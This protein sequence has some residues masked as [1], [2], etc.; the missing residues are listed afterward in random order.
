MASMRQ[1]RGV[2]TLSL[3]EKIGQMMLVGYPAGE[4]G[5]DV[6]RGV[7]ERRPMGNLILFAG[8]M[9]EPSVIYERLAGLR[10]LVRQR[11]GLSPLVS[12]DQEGGIVARVK[13][14]FTP[15]PGAMA[16]AAAVAGG[17]IGLAE[18][19]AM[20]AAVAAELRA[21]GFNWNLAPV[22]DV[23]VNRQNPVIGVRSFGEDPSAV[24]ELAAAY[25]RGL[26]R[27]GVA[28]TAKHFPGHGDTDLDSHLALPRVG[29]DLARL[30]AVELVPFRRLIAQGIAS[31]MTAHVL[32]PAVEPEPI[33]ATLSRR[34][35]SGLLRERLGYGGLIVTDC[36]EMKAI[37]GRY[38]DAAVLA[39][40]AGADVLCVSHTARLQ[41]AAFDAVKAA[42]LSGR[43]PESRIDES[44]RRVLAVKEAFAVEEEPKPRDEAVAS[45]RSPQALA[46][47]ERIADASMTVLGG[48]LPAASAGGLYLDLS[49]ETQT[50]VE[51]AALYVAPAPGAKPT[52]QRT[53]GA[54]T[55]AAALA[56]EG[57]ALELVE[58]PIDPDDESIDAAV[59]RIGRLPV[60][61]GLYALSR[62]PGQER[63]VRRVAEACAASGAPL[64]FVAMR[65]PY[66]V[67]LALAAAGGG[68]P[69]LCAYEYTEPS[70]AAAA[71]ALV[72]GASARGACPVTVA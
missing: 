47:A 33:P 37:H 10:A 14:G 19:E 16:M 64:A 66:D 3:D 18:V 51:S 48:S 63:L 35:L 15:M 41:E 2:E 45:L 6:M 24:A 71:R 34:V 62:Q 13:A 39:V 44:V 28:A 17:E 49:P 72:R 56:A 26:E 52:A 59:A 61:L 32:F 8:N 67:G 43:I 5:L 53:A 31:I 30:D 70:T 1:N 65:D 58:L 68:R 11:T 46:L 25:A 54:K 42:V 9:A 69:A 22:A 20:T 55:M 36:L 12:L 21:V 60:Y 27:A 7:I 57:S 29:A 23:N 40:E 38:D 50:G 4:A